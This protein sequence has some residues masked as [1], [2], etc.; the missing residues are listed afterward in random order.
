L[1]QE[2]VEE[3][4]FDLE[5]PPA[6]QEWIRRMLY[7]NIPGGKMNRG[8]TVVHSLEALKV[9]RPLSLMLELIERLLDKGRGLT[10]EEL[11]QAHVLGW[12]VEWLQAFFLISDDIMD[13]SVTRRGAPCWYRS[14]H[15]SDWVFMLALHSPCPFSP[16]HVTPT[17]TE[18]PH[19]RQ[20]CHQRFLHR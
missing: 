12:C 4:A 18:S 1:V 8:L 5:A 11:H 9:S 16:A 2:L 15:V 10:E 20:H 6:I 13:Q 14:P 7:Y 17:R 3:T 19:G